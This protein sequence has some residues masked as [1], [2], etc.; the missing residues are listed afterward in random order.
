MLK[1]YL[2][3]LL[4]LALITFSVTAWQRSQYFG[5]AMKEPPE[6]RDTLGVA[7]FSGK[8]ILEPKYEQ[9]I[10]VKSIDSFWVKL[11]R[12]EI[13]PW[14]QRRPWQYFTNA[15]WKLLDRN[16]VERNSHLPENLEPVSLTFSPVAPGIAYYPRFFQAAGSNGYAICDADGSPV[17]KAIYR[18]IFDVGDDLWLVRSLRQKSMYDVLWSPFQPHGGKHALPPPLTLI[19]HRGKTIAVLDEC[20]RGPN[21]KFKNGQMEC[22]KG[23]LLRNV[24]HQGK[25]T[26]A[27][28]EGMFEPPFEDLSL[29]FRPRNSA[30]LRCIM[31]ISTDKP[32]PLLP[33]KSPPDKN[34][35]QP[36]EMADGLFS[37]LIANN[38]SLHW[39]LIDKRGQWLVKPEYC[40]LMYCSQ[41]R[42]AASKNHA[43]ALAAQNV[44]FKDESDDFSDGMVQP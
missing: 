35:W 11:P 9:I 30:T 14:Y 40:R 1:R 18:E 44:K 43:R 12:S 5:P 37:V 34:D 16:G 8:W 15:R 28:R 19:D 38:A 42:I 13:K 31:P 2:R 21:G 7:D 23:C 20:I 22:N 29:E 41:D 3:L 26:P 27:F 36:V 25:E 24:D 17:T 39:G 10:Y 4:I 32:V 6:V 33:Y